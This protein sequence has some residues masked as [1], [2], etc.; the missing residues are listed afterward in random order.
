MEI[1]E[2]QDL[3][4]AEGCIIQEGWARGSM[5]SYDRSLVAMQN[6]MLKEW[7]RFLIIDRSGKWM[8]PVSVSQIAGKMIYSISYVDLS[9][10]TLLNVS[11][12]VMA[13]DK[14]KLGLSS[15]QDEEIN[16]S[17][18]E[19]RTAFIRRGNVHNIMLCAPYFD[20][21]N[22][23]KGIDARF[24][25]FHNPDHESFAQAT[26]LSKSRKSFLL[27]EIETCIPVKGV[28][29]RGDATNE[30]SAKDEVMAIY[31]WGRG[32]F[33]IKP[34]TK[35]LFC[36]MSGKSSVGVFISSPDTCALTI[37]G[38]THVFAGLKIRSNKDSF[39][40]ESKGSKVDFVMQ[41]VIEDRNS[42]V[43]NMFGR[44][45]GNVTLD[46]GSSLDLNGLLGMVWQIDRNR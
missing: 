33:P 38:K 4:N 37:D 1:V 14:T 34:M 43:L 10:K 5:W 3:L 26:T 25:L 23:G 7:D 19:M 46:D 44:I 12:K 2:R 15:H 6:M 27:N 9:G 31:D 45:E 17:C 24:E 16:Y 42:Q 30:I 35:A 39:R 36:G 21:P 32:R 28:L 22:L 13:T 18:E 29:R 40:V 11:K 8:V 20:I 41:P